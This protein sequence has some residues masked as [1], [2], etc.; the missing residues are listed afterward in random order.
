MDKS[1]TKINQWIGWSCPV[2]IG[3]FVFVDF[4]Y[5]ELCSK[6]TFFG[7]ILTHSLL[8]PSLII[9]TTLFGVGF[10]TIRRSFI[11]TTVIALLFACY[12]QWPLLASIRF[13]VAKPSFDDLLNRY[14]TQQPVE[15]PIWIGSYHVKD[16]Q[17]SK[18]IW[19]DLGHGIG[20]SGIV[21][22]RNDK[23]FLKPKGSYYI[24]PELSNHWFF[25]VD[26]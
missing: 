18:R 10:K 20:N 26:E 12:I 22:S 17:G 21:F 24:S 2:L 11:T 9:L 13:E 5:F 7:V 25:A 19:F 8:L 3:L 16:I 1:D 15:L 23:K 6:Q 14:E 4:F